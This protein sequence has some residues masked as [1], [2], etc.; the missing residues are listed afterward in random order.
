MIKWLQQDLNGESLKVPS[1]SVMRLSNKS[2]TDH[3]TVAAFIDVVELNNSSFS[4]LSPLLNIVSDF[5]MDLHVMLEKHIEGIKNSVHDSKK[6]IRDEI[7]GLDVDI[8]EQV[9]ETDISMP[10]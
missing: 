7:F 3:P 8:D 10:P 9:K 2:I 6:R 4:C 1:S 5:D